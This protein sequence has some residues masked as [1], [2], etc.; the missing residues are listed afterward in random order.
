MTTRIRRNRGSALAILLLVLALLLVFLVA[1]VAVGARHS[2]M[3]QGN[4]ASVA[5]VQSAESAIQA[6]LLELKNNAD[7]N[8]GFDN[9]SLGGE[10]DQR[11]SLSV[12]N[13]RMGAGTITGPGGV[14]VPAGMI[15]L[16]AT[17]TAQ[18]GQYPRQ[19]AVFLRR[20]P[21]FSYAIASGGEVHLNAAGIV[22]GTVKSN[23]DLSVDA[24]VTIVP[25]N[26]EGDLL[27]SGNLTVK[28]QA[29][30]DPG[31]GQD[32]RAR[33]TITGSDKIKG[34]SNIVA[35]D[36][37]AATAPFIVDGRLTNDP[38]AGQ[39]VMPN[40]NPTTLL[41][42]AVVHTGPTTYSGTDLNLNGQ[43]HYFPDGVTFG[44]GSNIIGEGTIVVGNGNAA[45]FNTP[46]NNTFNVV[47]LDGQNG[48][49]GSAAI[50]FNRAT[51]LTGLVFC[52]GSIYSSSSFNVTGRV[53][54][55]GSG[56]FVGSG[57]HISGTMDRFT[58]PGF[59]AF[60]GGGGGPSNTDIS[61]W[62]RL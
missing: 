21:L 33:G 60:F 37:S 32:A 54:A 47:A 56:E 38:P 12:T 43:V 42:D 19:V 35:N 40:P 6:G 10:Q 49:V 9:V 26:G 5:A 36:T 44:G 13:N 2:R 30:M 48:T 16:L 4:L 27:T 51:T 52:Q 46:L 57:A 28:A 7:W 31:P 17:G 58:C 3:I 11:Y 22:S 20:G 15:Y 53:I 14:S 24:M 61:S 18:N 23:G 1:V 25:V 34:A 50:Y 55:Y 62:Q 39:E 41:A 45:T 8:A 59:E 29:Q